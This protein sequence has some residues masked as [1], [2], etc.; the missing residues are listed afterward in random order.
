MRYNTEAGRVYS[1]GED[2]KDSGGSTALR[3]GPELGRA[4][5]KNAEDYVFGVEQEIDFSVD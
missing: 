2:L 3:P 4:F 5:R 1:V